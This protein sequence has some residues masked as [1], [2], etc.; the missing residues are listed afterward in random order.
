MSCSQWPLFLLAL[1][2]SGSFSPTGLLG[3]ELGLLDLFLLLSF[4]TLSLIL[5]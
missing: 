1:L 2:S 4:F 5:Y 3:L